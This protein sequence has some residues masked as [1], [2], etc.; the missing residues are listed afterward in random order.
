MGDAP[1]HAARVA[2]ELAETLRH[3]VETLTLLLPGPASVSARPETSG[4]DA[5]M[6]VTGSAADV[7][8]DGYTHD[9]HTFGGEGDQ[10]DAPGEAST[11]GRCCHDG[12]PSD[13]EKGTHRTSTLPEPGPAAASDIH[14]EGQAVEEP[15]ADVEV[16]GCSLPPKGERR[17]AV[18]EE[19]PP[20]DI[21]D[22][23]TTDGPAV[24]GEKGTHNLCTLG[25]DLF[26]KE[27]ENLFGGED[28]R[29][30]DTLGDNP[31]AAVEVLVR[32]FQGDR[33][34]E[35]VEV[36][37][38]HL[39]CGIALIPEAAGPRRALTPGNLDDLA[40]VAGGEL[41]DEERAWF[42]DEF[43]V[44]EAEAVRTLR[45]GAIER[46]KGLL[47]KFGPESDAAAAL[48]RVLASVEA[49]GSSASQGNWPRWEPAEPGGR[50]EA[51]S[52]PESPDGKRERRP[53]KRHPD[54]AAVVRDVC[55][56]PGLSR[57]RVA[58][59]F[60]CPIRRV[61][62]WSIGVSRPSEDVIERI[63]QIGAEARGTETATED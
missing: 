37:A 51:G 17:Q 29:L 8:P 49:G 38:D 10:A 15:T 4:R 39:R 54:T 47:P 24:P 18:E 21:E 44:I 14:V 62:D 60:G 59:I 25:G 13:A 36:L 50:S 58:E 3:A 56:M 27:V 2:A 1:S 35:L 33:L 40:A 55:D 11:G 5:L 26:H 30:T 12:H 22:G 28:V 45:P 42:T 46:L 20:T 48:G 19:E 16:V 52:R 34:R 53:R 63:R 61:K 41:P 6:P 57:A 31:C 43:R 32:S 7:P 9:A 23:S